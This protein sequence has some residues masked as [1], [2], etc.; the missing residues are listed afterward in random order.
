MAE[1]LGASSVKFNIVQPTAR[2]ESFIKKGES[3][4]V[5]DLI[6]LGHYTEEVI[7]KTT[8]LELFFDYPN[9]FRS[10]SRIAKHGC[11]E[12]AILNIIGV[13]ADGH[14]ALCG[15]GAHVKELVFGKVGQDSLDEV[16]RESEILKSLRK[17]LPGNLQGVCKQCILRKSCLG[18]CIAQNYYTGK[19]LWSSFW[20][21]DEAYREGLFPRTRLSDMPRRNL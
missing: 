8:D 16:W 19:T 6:R 4:S 3:L 10:L 5:E 7:A 21:C 17:G 1:D 14:Y 11:G 13:I 9:A 2:G 18:R 15:I 12:C 20:F